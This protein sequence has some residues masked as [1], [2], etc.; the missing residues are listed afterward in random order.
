MLL[1]SH[2]PLFTAYRARLPAAIA[3]PSPWPWT[4]MA[5][6]QSPTTAAVFRSA[7]TTRKS[8]WSSPPRTHVT[9]QAA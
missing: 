1:Q 2:L 5:P 4:P 6:L 7:S 9:A 8:R 3:T